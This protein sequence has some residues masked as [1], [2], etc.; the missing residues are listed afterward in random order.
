MH[1]CQIERHAHLILHFLWGIVFYHYHHFLVWASPCATN[2]L[3]LIDYIFFRNPFEIFILIF[4]Y[5]L[6][7]I[8]IIGISVE[9]KFDEHPS[10]FLF[11]S[12][13]WI[14]FFHSTI[15]FIS[16]TQSKT[17]DVSSSIKFGCLSFYQ[18]QTK[19]QP[20][21]SNINI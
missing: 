1:R 13:T 10:H 11:V 19:N 21:I 20:T 5:L 4:L 12:E 14:W 6:V 8:N 7:A 16:S 2:V 9:L 18:S 3:F 15:D 17:R